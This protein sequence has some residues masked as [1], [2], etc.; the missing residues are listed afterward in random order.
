MCGDGCK[1]TP[2]SPATVLP[3]LVKFWKLSWER[4]L[5]LVRFRKLS[6]TSPLYDPGVMSKRPV[7][8]ARSTA[9]AT[10]FNLR[11]RHHRSATRSTETDPR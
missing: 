11:P 1:A 2:T 6:Q 9:A 3:P 7:G 10:S 5:Q 8:V 4:E